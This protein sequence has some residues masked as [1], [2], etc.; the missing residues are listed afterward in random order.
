MVELL[1]DV[2]FALESVEE[3]RIGLHL[4]MRDFDGDGAIVAK[5]GCLKDRGHAAARDELVETV[6][7]ELIAGVEFVHSYRA[8]GSLYS[9]PRYMPTLSTDLIRMI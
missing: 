9:L 8:F 2:R 1:A 4:G 5:V 3:E 6:M 7:I